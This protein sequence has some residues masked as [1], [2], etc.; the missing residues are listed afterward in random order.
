[1]INYD[2]D[3]PCCIFADGRV[4]CVTEQDPRHAFV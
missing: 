4:G 3:T 2:G 1:M